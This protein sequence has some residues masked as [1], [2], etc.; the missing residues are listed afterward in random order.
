M[1]QRISPTNPPTGTVH[2][3]I[4]REVQMSMLRYSRIRAFLTVPAVALVLAACSG[5]EEPFNPEGTSED[6]AAVSAAFDA[7]VVQSFN[8]RAC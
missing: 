3:E 6:M 5:D 8:A 1:L 7:P 2:P 4:L